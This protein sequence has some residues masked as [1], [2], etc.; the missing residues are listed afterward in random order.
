MNILTS[1]I[2]LFNILTVMCMYTYIIHSGRVTSAM[3]II[4]IYTSSFYFYVMLHAPVYFKWE[5]GTFD[6]EVHTKLGIQEKHFTK[7]YM[8]YVVIVV[9]ER[10]DYL[11][12][13]YPYM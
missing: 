10:S 7:W 2:V 11:I 12:K 5:M 4:Y 9:T 6:V 3:C 8:L 13:N 1:F